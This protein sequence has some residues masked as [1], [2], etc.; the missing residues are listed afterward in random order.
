MSEQ[1]RGTTS[2]LF[3]KQAARKWECKQGWSRTKLIMTL[4]DD[5]E[6]FEVKGSKQAFFLPRLF[7]FFFSSTAFYFRPSL[8]RLNGVEEDRRHHS[9][10]NIG[11]TGSALLFLAT[12]HRMNLISRRWENNTEVLSRPELIFH[13]PFPIPSLVF[14][15]LPLSHGPCSRRTGKSGVKNAFPRGTD[16]Y[17]IFNT[18]KSYLVFLSPLSLFVIISQK[19]GKSRALTA[20]RQSKS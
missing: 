9:V 17:H 1:R 20:A 6:L 2:S 8:L 7:C 3:D 14:F 15:P 16:F 10:G 13:I 19:Q 12:E 5:L 11:P 4:F 18:F